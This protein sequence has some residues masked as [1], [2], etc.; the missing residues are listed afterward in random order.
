M[1]WTVVLRALDILFVVALLAWFAIPLAR[2]L[3]L[4]ELH[5]GTS[6]AA[7]AD[8]PIKAL[9]FQAADGVP[10]VGWIVPASRPAPTVILIPGF[11]ADRMSMIPYARMLRG[12]YTVLLYDSRGTGQSGGDFSFGAGEVNDVLGALRFV[13]RSP[14]LSRRPIGL[15][16]VSLGS[17]DAIVA[18][19]RDRHARAVV[20]DSPYTDQDAVINALNQLHAGPVTL[21]LAPIAAFLI[22]RLCH[23]T[24]YAF[25]PIDVVAHISP[26]ALLLIHARHD[27]NPTTPLS[28]AIRLEHA[29]GPPVSLWIAPRGGHAQALSAQPAQY[30][31]HVFT[32]FGRYLAP[33]APGI[34]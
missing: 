20:A 4:V 3:E 18:A 12:R 25:R 24:I 11:K 1:R 23:V 5:G 10:L 26:R 19:A 28:A 8:L 9:R 22:D 17:G 31:R 33:G 13:E 32:F 21:P 6:I 29:A 15:L 27:A 14:G 30:R 7:P 16:G 2:V 34:P